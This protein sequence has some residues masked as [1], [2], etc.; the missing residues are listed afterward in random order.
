MRWRVKKSLFGVSGFHYVSLVLKWVMFAFYW[1]KRQRP[2]LIGNAWAEQK[3]RSSSS[4]RS[5]YCVKGFWGSK[6]EPLCF[7]LLGYFS[8]YFRFPG[9][10]QSLVT[11]ETPTILKFNSSAIRF[12]LYPKK[13]FLRKVCCFSAIRVEKR[14]FTDFK[15]VLLDVRA[16]HNFSFFRQIVLLDIN[17]IYNTDFIGV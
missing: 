3:I 4:T 6:F 17:N 14:S 10:F 12:S 9:Q 2:V 15:I 16:R 8:V 5:V 7:W 11:V 13:C 1:Q